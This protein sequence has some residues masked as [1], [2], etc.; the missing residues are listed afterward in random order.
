MHI[1]WVHLGLYC[2]R[3]NVVTKDNFFFF[4]FFL[5]KNKT[6]DA[7]WCLSVGSR[8]ILWCSGLDCIVAAI[9]ENVGITSILII[10][11]NFFSSGWTL[12]SYKWKEKMNQRWGKIPT[13]ACDFSPEFIQSPLWINCRQPEGKRKRKMWYACH[14]LTEHR[15]PFSFLSRATPNF[16]HIVVYSSLPIPSHIGIIR[17]FPNSPPNRDYSFFMPAFLIGVNDIVLILVS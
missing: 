14:W 11:N 7:A 17:T 9:G 12:R 5:K 2:L 4:F 16:L 15:S 3:T 1:L 10:K 6:C 8:E 13:W